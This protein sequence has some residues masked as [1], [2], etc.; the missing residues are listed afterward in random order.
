MQLATQKRDLFGRQ[1]KQLRQQGLVPVELYGHGIGNEHLSVS[2]KEFNKV[3][4]EAGESTV[5][6]LVVGEEKRPVLIHNVQY[7]PITDD[8]ISVDFYQVRMDEK[9]SAAVELVFEGE[10]P[11]VK[12]LGAVL[13]KSVSE[14]EVEALPAQLPHHLTVDLTKLVNIGDSIHIKD[15]A[16]PEGVEVDADMETVIATVTEKMSEEEDAALSAEADVASIATEAEV[17]K[18]EEGATTEGGEPKTE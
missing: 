2:S 1:V 11:A 10:S 15:L 16:I 4:N 14:L 17:K 6:E 7:H 3:L 8:V 18:P 5:V 13:V 9:I 12:T